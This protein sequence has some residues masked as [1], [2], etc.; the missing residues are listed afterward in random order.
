MLGA[1]P[2]APL[3]YPVSPA[4]ERFGASASAETEDPETAYADWPGEYTPTRLPWPPGQ[5]NLGDPN[6]D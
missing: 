2:D 6:P 3:R 1:R 4:A 5:A